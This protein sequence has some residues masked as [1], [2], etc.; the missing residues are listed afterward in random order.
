MPGTRHGSAVDASRHSRSPT[1]CRARWRALIRRLDRA[2][3]KSGW[4]GIR[5]HERLSPLPVFKVGKGD[6]ETPCGNTPENK[7][8]T[9]LGPF[10]P[11]RKAS[12]SRGETEPNRDI[13]SQIETTHQTSHGQ[14]TVGV[15]RNDSK[16]PSLGI[17][18]PLCP[19]RATLGGC[20]AP[21]GRM[22]WGR[23]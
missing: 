15:S 9:L 19:V 23:H 5:T 22:G 7:A 17:A 13:T 1:G 4:G 6:S 3:P 18:P 14:V 21:A 12:G 10:P 11:G 16:W 2:I 8:E 20:L